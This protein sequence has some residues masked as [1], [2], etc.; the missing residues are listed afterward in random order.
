MTK[1]FISPLLFLSFIF[2]FSCNSPQK[3]IENEIIIPKDPVLLFNIPV[4]SFYVQKES[5]KRNENLVDILLKQNVSY[6]RITQLLEIASPIFDVRRINAGNNYYLFKDPSSLETLRYFAYEK[7]RVEYVVFDLR[8]TIRAAVGRKEIIRV[9]DTI[10]GTVNSSLWNAMVDQKANPE[11][12]NELSGIYSWA[13]DFFGIQKGDTFRVYYEQLVID[14]DTFGIGRIYAASFIHMNFKYNAYYFETDSIG[15]YFD[16]NGKSLRK[17]FLKAPLKFN[18]VSSRFSNSRLHPV[19]KI[20]RP[21]HGVD[22]AASSGT[23]IQ[24]IG[25]GVITKKAYQRTGGGNY[26]S[27]K[28]NGTYSTTYMHMKGYAKNMYVGKTVKQGDVIGY[29]GQTGLATGPHLDFRVYKNGTPIDPL[30]MSSPP[31]NPVDKDY[32]LKFYHL[33]DSMNLILYPK[34]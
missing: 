15:E 3:Q 18:R 17:T 5:V 9:L 32:L 6:A 23:P 21:H 29:V 26:L 12:A 24:T 2:L 22:Y 4:D 19:L 31:A 28:H 7:N 1:Y 34:K 20:R 27:I 10:D 25:D 14:N 8:D 30:K 33:R 11:L 13:I 16:E